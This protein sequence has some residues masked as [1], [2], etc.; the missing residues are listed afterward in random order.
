MA[1]KDIILMIGGIIFLML[2]FFMH[3]NSRK[4]TDQFMGVIKDF[5]A[6]LDK[7]NEIV[8]A[9]LDALQHSAHA[10]EGAITSLCDFHNKFDSNSRPMWFVPQRY[11]ELQEQTA[12]GVQ[13]Q[14]D[15]LSAIAQSLRELLER[16]AS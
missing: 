9:K 1:D 7:Q 11:L 12:A 4:I 2:Q 16:K 3:N 6:Y 8:N 15:A 14:K 13:Q 5:R 10:S